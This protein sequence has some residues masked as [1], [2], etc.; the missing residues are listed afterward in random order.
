MFLQKIDEHHLHNLIKGYTL[1]VWSPAKNLSPVRVSISEVAY[2]CK[3]GTEGV[4]EYQIQYLN[5]HETECVKLNLKLDMKGKVYLN[6]Q[7]NLKFL[8]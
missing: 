3:K 6:V 8:I 4:I 2:C 1:N 7:L 5:E